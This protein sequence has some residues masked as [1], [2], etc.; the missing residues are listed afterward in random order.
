MRKGSDCESSADM[1]LWGFRVLEEECRG[2]ENVPMIQFEAMKGLMA[3]KVLVGDAASIG[4]SVRCSV[5]ASTV[6]V[7]TAHFETLLRNDVDAVDAHY[8]SEEAAA[9]SDEKKVQDR[10]GGPDSSSSHR[11]RSL[12][13]YAAINYVGA[14]KIAKMFDKIAE[15]LGEATTCRAFVERILN[16]TRF[17]EALRVDEKFFTELEASDSLPGLESESTQSRR[18]SISPCCGTFGEANAATTSPPEETEVGWSFVIEFCATYI[19]YGFVYSCR[20]ALAVAKEPLASSLSTAFM[21]RLDAALLLSYVSMQLVVANF[22][23]EIKSMCKPEILVP[24]AVL[25]SSVATWATGITALSESGALVAV[26]WACNGAAQA[27][28]YPYV[29]VLLTAQIEPNNRG[30]VMGA[31]N[32]CSATGGAISAAVSAAA[33]KRRGYVGAFEGPALTTATCGV[34]L[35]IILNRPASKTTTANMTESTLRNERSSSSSMPKENLLSS[36]QGNR[37]VCVWRMARV[38]AISFAY[39]LVKPIRYLFLFWHNFYLVAVLQL[40][41]ESAALVEAVE[42]LSALAGGLAFG[43]ASDRCSPF[44]LFAVCLVLLAIS[45]AVFR[46]LSTFSFFSNVAVV[47]VTSS[48]VGAVDNLASGLTA[49]N[50]VEL[51]ERE[52]GA[53]ASIASVVSFLSASGTIGTILHGSIV[54]KLV[55]NDYW[56]ALFAIAAVQAG[57]AALLISPMV[58]EDVRKNLPSSGNAQSGIH[59]KAD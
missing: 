36:S 13:R 38:P 19:T 58:I 26:F 6:D 10:G 57:F 12:R 45:L 14:R 55:A 37:R 27:L 7:S 3:K 34:A 41:I 39:S 11:L 9:A 33:L 40:S 8:V 42:T 20:R 16:Q 43:Y 54:S 29:C 5:P 46:P 24:T 15:A 23:D 22:G 25:A 4:A 35:A 44:I 2:D 21:G 32:T 59:Q 51:N 18:E 47:A 17:V 48:L 28:V 30:R 52:C 1:V 49:A 50:L 31:W 53:S 56:Y